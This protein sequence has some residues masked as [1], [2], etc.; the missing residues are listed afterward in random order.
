MAHSPRYL[1]VALASAFMTLFVACASAPSATQ[2]AEATPPSLEYPAA[3]RGDVVDDYHGVRIA[4]GVRRA[5]RLE[6]SGT[7]EG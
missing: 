7:G 6:M 5:K 2:T 4:E 1:C 3:P